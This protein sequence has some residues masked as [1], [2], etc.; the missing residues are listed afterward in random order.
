MTSLARMH[1]VVVPGGHLMA[2]LLGQ[3][4]ANLRQIEA[5]FP[6]TAHGAPWTAVRY[7]SEEEDADDT[8]VPVLRAAGLDP[9]GLATFL[10]DVLLP[11]EGTAACKDLLAS[12]AIPPYGIDLEDTHHATCWR[13]FHVRQLAAGGRAAPRALT[14]QPLPPVS[15]LPIVIPPPIEMH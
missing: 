4:D 14:A 12:G 9:A 2:A 8:S 1:T 3:R 15:R 10:Q 5:A 11:P 7:F 13:V 6:D